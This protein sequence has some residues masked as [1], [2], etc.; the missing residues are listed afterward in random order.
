[1]ECERF[2][3]LKNVKWYYRTPSSGEKV[4]YFNEST[5]RLVFYG[6]SKGLTSDGRISIWGYYYFQREYETRGHLAYHIFTGWMESGDM[7]KDKTLKSKSY[8][9]DSYDFANNPQTIRGLFDRTGKLSGEIS[10]TDGP[11]AVFGSYKEKE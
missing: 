10:N 9:I 11:I 5:D 8:E 6:T 3:T 4:Y 7:L 2:D 1:M